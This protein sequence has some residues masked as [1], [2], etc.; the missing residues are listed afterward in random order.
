M[1]AHTKI[2]YEFVRWSLIQT[3]TSEIHSFVLPL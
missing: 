1:T 3:W 2:S